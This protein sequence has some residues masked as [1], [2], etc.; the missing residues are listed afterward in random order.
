M[1]DKGTIA[2]ITAALADSLSRDPVDTILASTGGAARG[3]DERPCREMIDNPSSDDNNN[4]VN[5]IQKRNFRDKNTLQGAR[6]ASRGTRG[7]CLS[8]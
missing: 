2:F 4:N 3:E 5:S 7:G 8:R 1:R 6:R